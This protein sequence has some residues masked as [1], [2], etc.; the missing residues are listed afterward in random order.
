MSFIS[1]LIRS[2]AGLAV[3]VPFV[4]YAEED[5]L[6]EH[7]EYETP[8]LKEEYW[9]VFPNNPA[10]D[11]AGHVPVVDI[12]LDVWGK[13]IHAV[14]VSTGHEDIAD[15]CIGSAS[16]MDFTP[17]IACGEPVDGF[18]RHAFQTYFYPDRHNVDGTVTLPAAAFRMPRNLL[19]NLFRASM[20]EDQVVLRFKIHVGSDGKIQEV[21]GYTE[22]ERHLASKV[23]PKLTEFM[24]FTPAKA[25]GFPS[26]SH[27]ILVMDLRRGTIR[28]EISKRLAM[29]EGHQPMPEKLEA[30][31]YEPGKEYAVG[32][33]LYPNGTVQDIQFL[34][35]LNR[36]EALSAINAFRQWRVEPASANKGNF[37]GIKVTYTYLE[38]EPTAVML[39]DIENIVRTPP[40]PIKR[41]APHYPSKLRREGLQ[42]YAIVE[43]V[44]CKKGRVP[45]ARAAIATHPWFGEAAVAAVRKWKFEPAT[46]DGEPVATYVRVPIPFKFRR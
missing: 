15:L 6:A 43:F 29:A 33:S 22:W 32:L 36:Q 41:P 25:Q 20:V 1:P 21:V 4:V 30:S 12:V 42:G 7:C 19:E 10:A 3:L 44:V 23:F 24:T 18:Y 8:R 28:N 11:E 38:D 45:T 9:P 46:L 17:A 14:M 34:T 16:L 26:E 37:H 40:K 35:V 13:P 27:L 31:G 5:T 2:M 39:K